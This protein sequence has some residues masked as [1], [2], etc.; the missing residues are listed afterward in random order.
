[1][2]K[3]AL[4]PKNKLQLFFALKNEENS[5]GVFDETKGILDFLNE[6]W[7]LRNLPS[8]DSRFKNAYDDIVQHTLNNNDWDDDHLFLERLKLLE[9]DQIFIKFLETIVNPKFRNN[10]DEIIR[11]VLLINSYLEKDNIELYRSEYDDNGEPIYL[12]HQIS[13]DELSIYHKKNTIPFFV[14]KNNGYLYDKAR[15]H[16]QPL[17]FPSFVLAHNSGWNDYSYHTTFYLFFYP[18]SGRVI[19]IGDVKIMDIAEEVISSVPNEFYNLGNGF[20]SLGQSIDYYKNLK[21]TFGKNHEDILYALQDVAFFHNIQEKFEK[22]RAF[23]LSLIR[24]NTAERLLREARYVIY[25][26]DLSNLYSFEYSFSTKYSKEIIN[27]GFE[28]NNQ[29]VFPNRVYG[30]IGKN[31]TGKTQLITRLPEDISLKRN[32]NFSP[33]TPLFS[34]I[35]AVSYSVFDSFEIPKTT[36]SFNYVYCGI[37]NDKGEPFSD[38]GLLLRFH[39]SWKKIKEANRMNQWKKVLLNFIENDLVDEFIVFNNGSDELTVDVAKFA[40]TRKKLSSGQSIILYI[41]SEIVANIRY[42]S[43]LLFDEPETH[44]HPNAITQLVNT[45]YELVNEFESYC[46]ITTHSPLILREL[47]SKNVYVIEKHES[48][49]SIRK[50]GIESFGENSSVLTEEVFGNKDIP[51]HYKTKIQGLVNVGYTY[52]AIISL[53]ETDNVPLSLNAK[54]YIKSLINNRDA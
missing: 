13:E 17:Q 44:L 40:D 23:Q 46:I 35:I 29:G 7:D 25:D 49:P 14:D 32:E 20:C 24:K 22:K 42:D 43:L 2:S 3:K 19:P 45:I 28:F 8:Q 51:K 38:K 5:F 52:E 39:N 1:M 15:A 37:R 21:N 18:E 47:F 48:I 33:R 30:I 31:G 6:I 11:F 34:K 36:T 26:F 27:I 10:E 9:N 12:I 41:I 50:I 4:N 53:I 54:I 16:N